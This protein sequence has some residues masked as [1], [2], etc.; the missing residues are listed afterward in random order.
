[1]SITTK[2]GCL[3]PAAEVSVFHDAPAGVKTTNRSEVTRSAEHGLVT[4]N[5]QH[6]MD[7][8]GDMHVL[9][10]IGTPS[11]AAPVPS[12]SGDEKAPP[13]HVAICWAA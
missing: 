3:L 8:I 7:A 4:W 9:C 10:Q 12:F 5:S 11:K 13:P 1:V 6:D 2:S